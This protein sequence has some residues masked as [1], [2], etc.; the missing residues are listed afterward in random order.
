MIGALGTATDET[1]TLAVA[2]AMTPEQRREWRDGD[3]T[4]RTGHG[5]GPDF[6]A[7]WL[8]DLIDSTYPDEE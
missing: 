2:A 4:M 6:D 3:N 1:L 5:F 7:D 8:A